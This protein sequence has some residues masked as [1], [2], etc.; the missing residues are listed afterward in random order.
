MAYPR[1][2]IQRLDA[3]TPGEQPESARVVKL[4]TNENPYPPPD[5]VLQAIQQ[6]TADQLRRYPP[7]QAQA[8]RHTAA[9]CHGVT[10]RQIIATNG[11]DELLRLAITVFCEPTGPNQGEEGGIGITD[12][13]YSLYPVLAA[14]HDTPVVAVPLRE[15]FTLPDDLAEQWNARGCRLGILVNPHAPSG[16]LRPLAQLQAIAR[17]FRGVLLIDEAY[18]DFADNDALSLVSGAS[19]L[20]NVLILRTLS[21]GYSLAGL[22]FGYGIGHADLIAALD[23]ARDSYNTDILSQAAATAA[24]QARE[25]ASQTWQAVITERTRLSQALTTRGWHIYPSQTNF[26][27]AAPPADGPDAARIYQTLKQQHIFVRY[28]NQPRLRDKLRIT[29]GRPEQND[30]LL[31]AIKTIQSPA[32][33]TK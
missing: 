17:Q 21:K 10:A 27:L 19:P 30:R 1:P 6:V 20:E 12:P 16:L 7:P 4:N 18:V 8:F 25:Q 3:Y 33:H 29:I 22:R 14:I 23:K 5:A 2:N 32:G 15:D 24:L 31:D 11:G 26:L 9:Q 13:T 28:F